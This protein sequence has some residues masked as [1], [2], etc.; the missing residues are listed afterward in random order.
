MPKQYR[1]EIRHKAVRLVAAVMEEDS[2]LTEYEA[3][4]RVAAKMHVAEE[5]VRRWL[6]KAQVDAGE[7][8]GTTSA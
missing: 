8:T 7:R 1:P 2:V 5:T 4:R 3:I 6:R